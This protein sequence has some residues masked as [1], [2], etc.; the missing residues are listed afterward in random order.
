LAKVI[1]VRKGNKFGRN[2]GGA[3]FVYRVKETL[4]RFVDV[5]VAAECGQASL[6]LGVE[7]VI[8]LH[9]LGLE[10]DEVGVGGHP[11]FLG[12]AGLGG[13]D[14]RVLV[15]TMFDDSCHGLAVL[16]DGVF[17]G[18]ENVLEGSDETYKSQVFRETENSSGRTILPKI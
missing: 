1:D 11:E 8:G 13:F 9:P 2:L 17:A 4:E 16:G 6:V 18:G 12:N 15:A 10:G 3:V 14:G 5:V 7:G